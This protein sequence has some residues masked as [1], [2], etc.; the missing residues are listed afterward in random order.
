MKIRR[1]AR[2]LKVSIGNILSPLC[3]APDH[4]PVGALTVVLIV[5]VVFVQLTLNSGYGPLIDYL[6][7][8]VAQRIQDLHHDNSR[9]SQPHDEKRSKG[10]EQDRSVYPP[11]GNKSDD[12]VPLTRPSPHVGDHEY[13]S[14]RASTESLDDNAF[15]HPATYEGYDTIWIPED[16]HGFSRAEVDNTRQ[17][18]VDV[19]S[20]G[21]RMNEKGTVDV[22]RAPPGEDWDPSQ[23]L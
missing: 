23:Q 20:D 18:G 8:S 3:A 15:D 21:A 16:K 9:V 13:N 17:A 6:P 11:T 22:S 5:F 2:S 14:D 12:G 19:S 1:T 7:L 10:H 4:P